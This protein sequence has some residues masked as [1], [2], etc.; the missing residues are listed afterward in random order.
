MTNNSS[1]THED[2][3]L[4]R[5]LASNYSNVSCS[6]TSECDSVKLFKEIISGSQPSREPGTAS[7]WIQIQHGGAGV[8]SSVFLNDFDL[9]HVSTDCIKG[10][11]TCVHY[12]GSVISQLKPCYVASWFINHVNSMSESDVYVL[13]GIFYG[14][15]ILDVSKTGTYECKNYSSITEGDGYSQMSCRIEQELMSGKISKASSPPQCIH[16][17]GAIYK[18]NGK[19][20]PI[21]DCKRPLS[22]SINNAMDTSCYPFSYTNL[23]SVCEFLN[24]HDFMG[25]INIENAYR[26]IN[27]LPCHV[28]FQ[29]FKWVDFEGTTTVYLDHCLCFGIKSAPYIFTQVGN[30]LVKCLGFHGIHNVVNYIDDFL[31]S[32]KTEDDCSSSM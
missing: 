22:K 6:N 15:P 14:F 12:I 4:D 3:L 28:T 7:R 32:E 21:T 5:D 1:L 29:A 18:K 27:I 2:T 10:V 23:D 9:I 11:C 16:A 20:R 30:F 8:P 13:Y 24:Y 26:S 25:V 31:I 19:I 17:L